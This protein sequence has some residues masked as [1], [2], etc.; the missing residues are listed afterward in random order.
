[1]VDKEEEKEAVLVIIT[2]L[3]CH[4]LCCRIKCQSLENSQK[5]Y[6]HPYN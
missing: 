6:N 1:M 5:L 3:D 4:S 2:F